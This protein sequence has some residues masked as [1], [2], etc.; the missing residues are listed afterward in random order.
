LRTEETVRDLRSAVDEVITAA[1]TVP[2]SGTIPGARPLTLRELDDFLAREI[3]NFD[4]SSFESLE[5][6][7]VE[8]R[9]AGDARQ[10]EVEPTQSTPGSHALSLNPLHSAPVLAINRRVREGSRY[11]RAN[12]PGGR[13]SESSRRERAA[14]F[15]NAVRDGL[16]GAADSRICA[17]VSVAASKS[18][19]HHA[20]PLRRAISSLHATL[21]ILNLP[22]RLV[23]ASCRGWVN[24][25]AISLALWTLIAWLIVV[26]LAR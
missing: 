2:P 13:G 14:E 23:P 5:H 9:A 8:A 26:L 3:A 11:D 7:L 19:W 4:E 10:R 18:S 16:E 6:A 20:A 12:A 17:P 22:L 24:W 1:A 25:L 15:A 21:T